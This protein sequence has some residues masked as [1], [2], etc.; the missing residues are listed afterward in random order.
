MNK[1]YNISLNSQNI[2]FNNTTVEILIRS[3]NT[4]TNIWKNYNELLYSLQKFIQI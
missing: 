3:I 2:S 1:A 4:I